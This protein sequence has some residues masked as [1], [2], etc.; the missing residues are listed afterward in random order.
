MSHEDGNPTG[1]EPVASEGRWW[2]DRLWINRPDS[3]EGVAGVSAGIQKKAEAAARG[4][5]PDY[6][7]VNV[8]EEGLKLK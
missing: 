2:N 3:L 5:V 4:E 1:E 7:D 8:A 6:R